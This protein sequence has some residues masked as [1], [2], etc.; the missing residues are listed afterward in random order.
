[1]ENIFPTIALQN[2]CQ[3]TEAITQQAKIPSGVEIDNAILKQL[4]TSIRNL[5]FA[6]YCHQAPLDET[7]LLAMSVFQEITLKL[8]EATRNW[9]LEIFIVAVAAANEGILE[10]INVGAKEADG[11]IAQII[12]NS[13]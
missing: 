4:T 8:Q 10:E 3:A 5:L 6:A 13:N 2:F 7:L 11:V 1:M 9:L 12:C